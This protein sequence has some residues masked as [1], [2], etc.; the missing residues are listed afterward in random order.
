[1][2]QWSAAWEEYISGTID[3]QGE[4]SPHV[5]SEHAKQ[6]IQS[7][8]INTTATSHDSEDDNDGADKSDQDD[9]LPKI[10]F[11]AADLTTILRPD[12]TVSSSD[13]DNDV[14]FR[15]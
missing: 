2:L 12:M 15:F 11:N 3:E 10:S 13:E 4:R 14:P 9:D 5:P 8:L 6:L 1:M 7:L